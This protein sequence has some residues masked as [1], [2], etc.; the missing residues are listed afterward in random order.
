M[1]AEV[2]EK[3]QKSLNRHSVFNVLYLDSCT[4]IKTDCRT[5]ASSVYLKLS[6]KGST[7]VWDR[8]LLE[9]CRHAIWGFNRFKEPIDAGI[10]CLHGKF[11]LLSIVLCRIAELSLNPQVKNYHLAWGILHHSSVYFYHSLP[12]L[13]KH[14]EEI[15]TEHKI[16]TGTAGLFEIFILE[17]E[18]AHHDIRTQPKTESLWIEHSKNLSAVKILLEKKYGNL[19][20]DET[21]SEVLMMYGSVEIFSNKILFEEVLADTLAFDALCNYENTFD[22]P[23]SIE[24]YLNARVVMYGI[25]ALAT[26]GLADIVINS[27][28]IDDFNKSLKAHKH[29]YNAR[30]VFMEGYILTKITLNDESVEDTNGKDFEFDRVHKLWAEIEYMYWEIES[31]IKEMFADGFFSNIKNEGADSQQKFKLTDEQL[32]ALSLERLGWNKYFEALP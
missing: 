26:L 11:H 17:H 21:P 22:L 28:S 19:I 14:I 2:I 25:A 15:E 20:A 1:N 27:S 10:N 13:T 24:F 5:T 6:Q 4:E 23:K 12:L 7:I 32:I 18:L 9:F 16:S 8:R 30:K 31:L 29:L 3:I